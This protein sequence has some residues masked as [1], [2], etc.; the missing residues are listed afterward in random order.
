MGLEIRRVI[1]G[2]LDEEDFVDKDV[3]ELMYRV[4][5]EVFILFFIFCLVFYVRLY[6]Y[7]V[8]VLCNYREFI[9]C[10]VMLLKL[11]LV[12]IRLG[13]ENKINFLSL[14][15]KFSFFFFIIVI[16]RSN[17]L[18]RMYVRFWNMYI[19]IIIIGWSKVFWIFF[20]F[21]FIFCFECGSWWRGLLNF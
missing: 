15:F 16:R 2:N 20:K 9:V 10:L 4:C 7:F 14:F 5:I 17:W 18:F 8:S 12:C 3:E 11:W 1:L 13:R 19:V 6:V 21:I